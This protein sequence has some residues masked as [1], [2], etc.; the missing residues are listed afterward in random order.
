MPGI[1]SEVSGKRKR[2]TCEASDE[3][4]VIEGLPLLTPSEGRRKKKKGPPH[5]VILGTFASTKSLG[6][7]KLNPWHQKLRA[8]GFSGSMFYGNHLNCFWCICCASFGLTR[9]ETTYDE[10][11]KLVLE[12]GFALWDVVKLARRKKGGS[13]DQDIDVVEYND[14]VAFLEENTSIKRIAIPVTTFNDFLFKDKRFKDALKNHESLDF[15]TVKD[16][17]RNVPFSTRE[18]IDIAKKRR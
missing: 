11:K 2:D 12:K 17:L 1:G 4:D 10:M 15:V 7:K 9:H 18:D 8:N 3:S 16:N 13:R 6:E 5:T 14:I